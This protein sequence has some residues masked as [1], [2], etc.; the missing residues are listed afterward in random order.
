MV[1]TP[2]PLNMSGESRW[3][4]TDGALSSSTMPVQRQ[5]PMLDASASIGALSPSRPMANHPCSGSQKSRLNA[6]F[7]AA[8]FE[9][10]RSTASAS[11]RSSPK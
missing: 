11:S 9:R 5:W 3:A 4:A 8:A 7:R 1:R 6:S 10:Q 2:Q